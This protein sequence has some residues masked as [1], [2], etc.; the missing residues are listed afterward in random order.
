MV[1]ERKEKEEGKR[2]NDVKAIDGTFSCGSQGRN[3]VDFSGTSPNLS[4][5]MLG[6]LRHV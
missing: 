1:R 5:A 2:S 6:V 4:L 3:S